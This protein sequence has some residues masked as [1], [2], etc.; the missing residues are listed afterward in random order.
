MVMGEP[1]ACL[2]AAAKIF[3][4]MLRLPYLPLERH[5]KEPWA[6]L[7]LPIVAEP[8]SWSLIS[9]AQVYECGAT[10]AGL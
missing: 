9:P 10:A 5:W 3:G 7:L 1:S 8:C 6:N 2:P 4:R